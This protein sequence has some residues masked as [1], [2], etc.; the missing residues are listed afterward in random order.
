M[1][2]F[3]ILIIFFFNFFFAT[4]RKTQIDKQKK[5][6]F[7][8]TFYQRV[9]FDLTHV[10]GLFAKSRNKKK[11]KTHIHTHKDNTDTNK[12]SHTDLNSN[13]DIRMNQVLFHCFFFLYHCLYPQLL[14]NAC[15]FVFDV[16]LLLTYLPVMCL[17]AVNHIFSHIWHP[18]LFLF[19]FCVC[20]CVCVCVS[21]LFS[22]SLFLIQRLLCV[23]RG[24]TMFF[25]ILVFFLIALFPTSLS[26]FAS[27]Y[28]LNQSIL[29]TAR[30][31][32]FIF[33]FYNLLS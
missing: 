1:F 6:S 23:M 13:K 19:L 10:V 20:V 5:N 14:I 29:P 11:R 12:H 4:H 15:Y 2:F 25:C 17:M 16:S 30:V 26:Q 22:R 9:L 21:L 27:Q 31:D 32:S 8:Y 18:K 28:L 33:F 7:P 24:N 3:C